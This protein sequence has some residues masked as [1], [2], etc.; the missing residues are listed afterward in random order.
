MIRQ[1]PPNS[2]ATSDYH[3]NRM[4]Q[5]IRLTSKQEKSNIPSDD[6]LATLPLKDLRML[7]HQA[8]LSVRFIRKQLEQLLKIRRNYQLSTKIPDSETSWDDTIY[9]RLIDLNTDDEIHSDT[10]GRFP[11]KSARGANYVLIF[12]HKG[13]IHV[14]PLNDRSAVSYVKAY[15]L[16][17]KFFTTKGY[18]I[19]IARLDNETSKQLEAFLSDANIPFQYVPPND[20]CINRAER[21]I[22][23]F[24]NHFISVLAT[25]DDSFPMAH[26]DELL[27]QTELT[28]SILRSF[29]CNTIQRYR[30][31]T[32][33]IGFHTTG[34]HIYGP[35]WYIRQRRIPRV[36]ATTQLRWMVPR[37]RIKTLSSFH[38][39]RKESMRPSVSNSQFVVVI[40]PE[41]LI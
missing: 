30:P 2:V 4:R 16:V 41:W 6:I 23:S 18:V 7:G 31:I 5:H 13:Y 10:T 35:G 17:I 24:K 3:L 28:L 22:Q 12:V 29:A 21:A 20:H 8:H 34:L 26:W 39:L 11:F 1:N 40:Y 19:D 25:I 32:A 9:S 27:L 33:S 15:R 37:P 14:Q 38:V 36:T